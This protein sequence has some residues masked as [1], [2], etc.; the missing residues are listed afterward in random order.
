MQSSNANIDRWEQKGELFL[1]K[2]FPLK[3]HDGAKPFRFE[4]SILSRMLF[5]DALFV[6]P[7]V[8]HN[9]DEDDKA[10]RQEHNYPRPIFPDLLNT[11]SKLGPIHEAARYTSGRQK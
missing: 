9:N 10:E 11:I 7:N 5:L 6:P 3:P 8:E 2:T 1:S 4:P